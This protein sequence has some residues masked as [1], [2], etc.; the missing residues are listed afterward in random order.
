M[1]GPE[2]ELQRG[3]DVGG[4]SDRIRP[5][6]PTRRDRRVGRGRGR[7]A[8]RRG[9]DAPRGRRGRRGRRE[10][11]RSRARRTRRRRC[12]T[13]GRRRPGGQMKRRD[14]DGRK[15][16][17]PRARPERRRPGR[18]RRP[19]RG[20]GTRSAASEGRRPTRDLSPSR[21]VALAVPRARVEP[22][23]V[24]LSDVV[25]SD[26]SSA[27]ATRIRPRRPKFVS[28]SRVFRRADGTQPAL[29]LGAHENAR[30][31][32]RASSVFA[33]EANARR[34]VFRSSRDA[35]ARALLE[36]SGE[37]V[38]LLRDPRGWDWWVGVAR[39]VVARRVVARVRR[40]D[41]GR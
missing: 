35:R 18:P 27:R 39:R 28:E 14:R 25:V 24:S 29:P 4:S 37:G 41:D 21:T 31:V 12:R 5:R 30:A 2:V 20:Q 22:I 38:P 1:R 16:R 9:R 11:R 7:R 3:V 8:V 19:S 32:R 23:V 13:R 15:G 40:R 34:S 10:R 26:C 36:G 6:V 17:R 33:R